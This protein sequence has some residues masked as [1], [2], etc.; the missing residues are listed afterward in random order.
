MPAACGIDTNLF[1]AHSTR[2]AA[3]TAAVQ[4]GIFIQSIKQHAHWALS[5]NTFET[6]YLKPNDRH[7]QGS[8]IT[9]AIFSMHTEKTHVGR[10]TRE[11]DV[12]AR[13]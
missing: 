10:A 13:P 11:E 8:Q 6:Y 5:S 4:Q 7:H 12:G 9:Q 1:K 2:S 3:S